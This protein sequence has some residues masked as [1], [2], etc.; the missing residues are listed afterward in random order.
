MGTITSSPSPIFSVFK[1]NP[2]LLT[3]PSEILNFFKK[4]KYY[5][6]DI[7]LLL[8][9]AHLK[10]SSKTLGF[11][12][13]KAHRDLSKII[14]AYHLSD[15]NGFQD[16]NQKFD[17]KSWFWKNLKKKVKFFTIEVY[18]VDYKVYLNLIKILKLKI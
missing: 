12:L 2:L 14:T 3:T 16:S 4:L 1:T 5:K 15:N 17:K 11:N 8:D 6:L 7:G 13:Q 18:N 10:V 9:V